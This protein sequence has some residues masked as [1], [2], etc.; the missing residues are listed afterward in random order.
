MH[1]QNGC[2]TSE[3]LYLL[4]NSTTHYYPDG[5]VLLFDIILLGI[6]LNL[7]IFTRCEVELAKTNSTLHIVKKLQF[8]INRKVT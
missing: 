8:L 5:V 4:K 6:L 2:V 3:L 7:N 1:N